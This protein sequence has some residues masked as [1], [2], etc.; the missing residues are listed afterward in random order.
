MGNQC[1]RPIPSNCERCN[2]LDQK[3][4]FL[5]THNRQVLDINLILEEDNQFLKRQLSQV[6]KDA[7]KIAG[8]HSN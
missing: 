3:I 2:K 4:D 7:N 1:R 6:L 8:K 5:N